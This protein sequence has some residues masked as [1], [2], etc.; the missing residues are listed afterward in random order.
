MDVA[1]ATRTGPISD[2]VA[3]LGVYSGNSIERRWRVSDASGRKKLARVHCLA[4]DCGVDLRCPK[5]EKL[6]AR[7][8]DGT[9]TTPL[10]I[11]PS[12]RKSGVP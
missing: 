12:D 10:A 8:P 6:A 11:F 4:G 9:K 2:I 3:V 5:M 7:D 1:Y